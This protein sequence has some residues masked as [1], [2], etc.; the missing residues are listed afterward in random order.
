[1]KS[2]ATLF[3]S[4]CIAALLCLYFI[5]ATNYYFSLGLLPQ[6]F[7]YDSKRIL[8]LFVLMAG[9]LLLML[10][11]ELRRCY[12]DLF[13]S[14]P[15]FIRLSCLG[16]LCL[17]LIS[18]GLAPLPKMALM[19]VATFACLFFFT[20]L[21]ACLRLIWQENFDLWALRLFFAAITCYIVYFFWIYIISILLK[22]AFT[23]IPGFMNIRVFAHY[24]AWTLP[25][26]LIPLFSKNSRAMLIFVALI[27]LLWWSLFWVESAKALLLAYGAAVMIS[28]VLF[29]KPAIKPMLVCCT[30]AFAGFI[31]YSLYF[32]LIQHFLHGTIAL[33]TMHDSVDV[34]WKLWKLS[35]HYIQLHPWLGLGPL[36][37]GYY[38]NP[39]ASGPSNGYLSI[40]TQWGIPTF[41][42]C[43]MIGVYS[44]RKWIRFV[45]K[46]DQV[47]LYFLSLSLFGALFDMLASGILN[48][49]IS[50]LLMVIVIGWMLGIYFGKTK[51]IK[52]SI[53]ANFL[54]L[55]CLSAV[56]ALIWLLP[57]Q[58]STL[59]QREVAWHYRHPQAI[60][61]PTYWLQGWINEP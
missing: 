46:Q 51:I 20:F 35:W 36:H 59:T 50:Q 58:L 21:I 28:L 16:I 9:L 3:S 53:Y 7:P 19:E 42:L 17:G 1:M 24:L 6:F 25:I 12:L 8:E 32:L 52:A 55:I 45:K 47:Q 56:C 43:L 13:F 4:V 61:F 34:R 2:S 49:P 39:W 23:Q 27:A 37:F 33:N 18:S 38:T 30:F 22:N 41:L 40:A 11:P 48:T 15:L 31:L 44:L 60:Y 26:L 5:I 29:K 14:L 54:W 10:T 57:P